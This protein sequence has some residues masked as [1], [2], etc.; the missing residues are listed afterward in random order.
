MET[1]TQNTRSIE[2]IIRMIDNG[3][4]LLP[5]FQRDF[6]WPI[7]KTETLFDSIFQDLFIGS[8][9][10]SKP[11]F[12]LACKKFDLRERGSKKHKPKPKLMTSN[13]FE[14][15]DIYT[16]LDGQQRTTAIYRALKG[17]DVI[18]IIFKDISALLSADYYDYNSSKIKVKYDEYVEGFDS[19]KP[20]DDIFYLRICDLYA[21]MDYRESKF[22]SEYIEPI[23]STF[24]LTEDEKNVLI[25]FALQLHKDFRSDIIKKSNLLSVQL[26]NMGLEKFCLYFER[27]NSQGLNLSFTDIITAKIYIDF[28]LTQN[29][30]DAVRTCKYFNEGL[31][32][33]IVRYINFI[34]N[35][36]VTKRSILR[37]LKGI[38]FINHW[39]I[40]I[41]DL[42]YIQ[43]WLEENNWLFKVSDMPYRSMLLPVLAFYQN[44]PNKE[45]S[46]AN[47]NQLDQ[48]KFWFYGSI[49]DNRYGGARHG[50]TNVV[51]K[52]DCEVMAALAK[53][54]N[55][56][57]SY[58]NNI[59]IEYSFE[60]FKKLD[61]NSNA[62]FMAISYFMWSK[63]RFKNLEN[64]ATVLVNN[65]I[66]IHHVF[67]SNYI[68][69][70]FGDNSM[71]YDL[72]DS[73]L[74][75]IRI[76]KISNIKISNKAPS[77]YLKE[78]K[79]NSP[80]SNI[81]DSLN[82]HF[83]GDVQ[84]LI[85]GQYDSDYLAFLLSRYSQ[86]EP[87]FNQLKKASTNLSNGKHI[88]I[89]S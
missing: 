31:I 50:S 89:W 47:Q 27:S 68:K 56:D 69:T 75:K 67:P 59:R 85:S 21:S 3:K 79:S 83:I 54:T 18:Y 38:H 34:S 13:E 60:E 36:E 42:D 16:L 49:L 58:W 12:D 26:L 61:N 65:N 72:A 29:I 51:I 35:G 28:K 45:F 66:E 73:I 2:D 23:V 40:T 5:E 77:T 62:K 52:K 9:I 70:T 11:K 44:L 84:D 57:S 4:L 48:L 88:D 64:N 76:N 37:D 15:D 17:M 55:P 20:K 7:E 71:E 19:V 30:A 81:E 43:G 32:D 6:K 10:V 46:Q 53:G 8:L 80:N 82:S 63:N 33:T 39:D 1:N 24:N 74:N 25:D 41:K 78:I 86:I 14:V 22:Q 87:L